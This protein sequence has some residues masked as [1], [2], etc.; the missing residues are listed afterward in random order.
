MIGDRMDSDITMGN[1][2]GIATGLVLTGV[3]RSID[4]VKEAT[5]G[6]M[7]PKYVLKMFGEL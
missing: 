3:T 1:R 6:E 7:Q 2:A 4:E 5:D